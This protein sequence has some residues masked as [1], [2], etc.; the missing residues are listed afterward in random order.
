MI[1]IGI[2]STIG[3]LL[4]L[5]GINRLLNRRR[6]SPSRGARW[7]ASVAIDSSQ[8]IDRVRSVLETLELA[9]GPGV[10]GSTIEAELSADWRTRGNHVF[11][12]VEPREHGTH[13]AIS[14]WPKSRQ[15]F[16]WGRSKRI[17][18]LLGAALD[19]YRDAT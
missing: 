13:V 1:A 15:L 17:V 2:A 14:S 12:H 6:H 7:D 8:V 19:P 16:D 18:N 3:T 4:L 9:S 5:A 10:A 11:V